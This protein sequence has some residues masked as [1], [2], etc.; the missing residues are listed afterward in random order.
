[1]VPLAE[2]WLGRVNRLTPSEDLNRMLL[3]AYIFD[4]PR[5]FG[6]ISWETLV[7]QPGPFADQPGLF[8]HDLV[9]NSLLRML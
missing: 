2:L 3:L 5:A 4:T 7:R 1:M 8:S 9:L 6:T